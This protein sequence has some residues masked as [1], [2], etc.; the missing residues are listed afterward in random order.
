MLDKL[1]GRVVIA[2]GYFDSVHLGH[3]MVIKTAKE[4][5]K[6]FGAK[7]VVFTFKGNL[8][9]T[10]SGGQGNVVYNA[11]ERENF[12]KDLGVDQVFFAPT[13]RKFLSMGKLAFLNYLNKVY[14][15][16]CYVSGEDYRFGKMGKGDVQYIER[17]AKRRGQTVKTVDTLNFE[18]G[19]ISTTVIKELLVNGKIEK[20]NQLL[21][22]SY[23]V[24]GTVFADRKVGSALGFPTINLKQEK[25]KQALKFG[26]YA[27]SVAFNGVKRKA[28]I[29][30]GARPTFDLE[31][32]LIEAHILN[33]SGDL[34]GVKVTVEFERFMREVIKFENKEQLV[35]QLTKDLEMV[36][37]YD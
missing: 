1:N 17:Y 20:A 5:A 36:K 29:N 13:S 4:Q 26:V 33:F 7:T 11:N 2:L 24:T 35:K 10:L 8:R 31:E 16:C 23:S 18:Y 6:K 27:G 28:L 14:D 34:Y 12:I 25:E 32:P 30:Y 9:A 21:G 3:Q 19:K 37:N 15:I 22:R